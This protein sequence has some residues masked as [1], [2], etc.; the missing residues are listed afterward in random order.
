MFGKPQV[1]HALPPVM[2]DL[3]QGIHGKSQIM[4]DL[5]QVMHGKRPIVQ[6]KWQAGS[7]FMGLRR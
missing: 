2:Y 4:H 3:G 6:L 7:D 1:I 5:P